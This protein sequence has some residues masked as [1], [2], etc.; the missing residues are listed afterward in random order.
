MA[1][2]TEAHACT[3]GSGR[4]YLH[5]RRHACKCNGCARVE[6]CTQT[7]A[8]AYL[9]A[10]GA[11]LG[12]RNGLLAPSTRAGGC[13][14]GSRSAHSGRTGGSGRPPLPVPIAVPVAPSPAPSLPPSSAAPPSLQSGPD[15]VTCSRNRD[16]E[17]LVHP[18]QT[19]VQHSCTPTRLVP[20]PHCLSLPPIAPQPRAYPLRPLGVRWAQWPP[21]PRDPPTPRGLSP[22]PPRALG[23]YFGGGGDSGPFPLPTL[24]GCPS[25]CDSAVPKER[26]GDTR[27]RLVLGE[28]KIRSSGWG[29]GGGGGAQPV[30]PLVRPS[31]QGRVVTGARQWGPTVTGM[32][33]LA[34]GTRG[35]EGDGDTEQS[36]PLSATPLSPARSSLWRSRCSG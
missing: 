33:T 19:P 27:R 8:C 29:M 15:S 25:P 28:E 24:G 14:W 11:H 1:Q 10:H 3:L 36:P 7:R 17:T 31:P 18:P 4:V 6:G 5:A 16:T 2:R 12:V 30:C 32:G 34:V 26:R 21:P 35:Q 20:A 22:R 23:L 9:H 13:A